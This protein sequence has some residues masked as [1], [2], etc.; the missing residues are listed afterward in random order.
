MDITT[1]NT[2]HTYKL[3]PE[4]NAKVSSLRGGQKN[5]IAVYDIKSYT[6]KGIF[7]IANYYNSPNFDTK[8]FVPIL[9]ASRYI[10]GKSFLQ[11]QIQFISLKLGKMLFNNQF[12]SIYFL[13]YGQQK[14]TLVTK[15]RNNHWQPLNI[16]LLEN[17]PW[18]LSL[19]LHTVKFTCNGKPIQPCKCC[20]FIFT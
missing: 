12:S 7:N 17:I 6:S 2:I 10:I 3:T 5:L 9:L 15:L 16:I 11:F 8:G 4:P 13:G 19:Y 14:G 20:I 1:N 18:Y